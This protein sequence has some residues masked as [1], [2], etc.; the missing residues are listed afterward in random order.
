MDNKQRVLA[1]FDR[2]APLVGYHLDMGFIFDEDWTW[3]FDN[4]GIWYAYPD[5][6]DFISSGETQYL[7]W[8]NT[9]NASNVWH[10]GAPDRLPDNLIAPRPLH[11]ASTQSRRG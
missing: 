2:D 10:Y 4:T 9:V 11:P 8:Y 3:P 7:D 1:N 6:V 5:F